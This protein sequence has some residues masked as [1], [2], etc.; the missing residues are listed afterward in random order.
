MLQMQ[1]AVEA[2]EDDEEGLDAV[3]NQGEQGGVGGRYA[4]EHQHGDDGKVPGTGS[5][6]GGNDDGEGTGHEYNQSDCPI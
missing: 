6:G 4:V 2:G 1:P 5:V 3:H